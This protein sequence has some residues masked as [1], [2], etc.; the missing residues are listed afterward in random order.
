[1]GDSEGLSSM[2]QCRISSTPSHSR[3]LGNKVENIKQIKNF[4]DVVRLS[5]STKARKNEPMKHI[6]FRP[7]T[8]EFLRNIEQRQKS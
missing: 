1:M 7:E 6:E 3:I 4:N 2:T 5:N 8:F